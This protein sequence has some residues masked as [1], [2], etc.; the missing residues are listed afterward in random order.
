MTE[1][2]KYTTREEW[3]IAAGQELRARVFPDHEIPPYRVSVGWPGGR[4]KKSSTIGQCWNTNCSEDGLAQVFVSPVVKSEIE[5]L[6]VLT[7][8]MIHVFD[9]CEHGHRGTFLQVFKA[10]GMTGKATECEA[11]KELTDKLDGIR[12]RLGPY[13]HSALRSSQKAGKLGEPKQKSRQLQVK[14]VDCGY[15]ARTTRMWLTDVGAPICPCNG[16]PMEEEVKS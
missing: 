16:E 8:E 4:G 10:V 5:V 11:S 15:I 9:N 13:P 1:V 3:L 12:K 14:C 2:Q 7:H 6:R